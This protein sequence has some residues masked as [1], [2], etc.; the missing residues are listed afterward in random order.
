[1]A[2]LALLLNVALN[3][4]VLALV[5]WDFPRQGEWTFSKR[6]ERFIR[7]TGWRRELAALV[8]MALLDP[9][10]PDGRHIQP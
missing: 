1:M 2:V 10:D 7:G 9:F 6:L 4:T 8:A 5:T 3:Y